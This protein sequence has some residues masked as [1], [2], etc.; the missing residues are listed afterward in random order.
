MEITLKQSRAAQQ[1]AFYS[2]HLSSRS[3]LPP[4]GPAQ[5]SP[6]QTLS[7][8]C[9]LSLPAF[10]RLRVP[11]ALA[12][13]SLSIPCQHNLDWEQRERD[14]PQEDQECITWKR[15]RRVVSFAQIPSEPRTPNP[16]LHSPSRTHIEVLVSLQK[17][18]VSLQGSTSKSRITAASP[19]SSS[20]LL[21][22]WSRVDIG[23][24][25]FPKSSFFIL[26]SPFCMLYQEGFFSALFIQLMPIHLFKLT[27]NI[28]NSMKASVILHL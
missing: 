26:H 18:S 21:G 17:P 7:R 8:G 15:H 27:Q 10:C 20:P 1:G 25:A 12:C 19:Y 16:Y 3:S 22:N 9:T 24:R 28:I 5:L 14:I 2:R 4:L 23:P 13:H 11:S 6:G